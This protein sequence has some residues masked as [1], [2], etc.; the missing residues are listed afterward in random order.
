MIMASHLSLNTQQPT[1]KKKGCLS[2]TYFYCSYIDM[3]Y[4]TAS[5]QFGGSNLT[6]TR[7]GKFSVPS[8]LVQII[9]VILY[10]ILFPQQV[11]ACK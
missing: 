4:F 11:P 2:S 3:T 1:T 7:C 10:W 5:N 6:T 9:T 8:A